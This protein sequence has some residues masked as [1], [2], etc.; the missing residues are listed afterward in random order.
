MEN[1]IFIF[2]QGE[3]LL[4]EGLLIPSDS[5]EEKS[6]IL[7]LIYIIP[8]GVT[9]SHAISRTSLRFL[10]ITGLLIPVMILS[11][12]ITSYSKVSPFTNEYL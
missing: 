3:K 9:E 12:E 7:W 2:F 10:T 4:I 8:L 11:L 1:Q 6:I 5:L